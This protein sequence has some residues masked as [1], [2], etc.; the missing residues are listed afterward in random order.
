MIPL[1]RIAM[2]IPQ[3]A[4]VVWGMP[5]YPH[6]N[7]AGGKLG[8]IRVIPIRS[9]KISALIANIVLAA[10]ILSLCFS[11]LFDGVLKG[12]LLLL[13]CQQVIVFPLQFVSVILRLN[14]LYYLSVRICNITLINYVICLFNMNTEST[15][16]QELCS[17][18]AL[19]GCGGADSRPIMHIEKSYMKCQSTYAFRR[20]LHC[21]KE[22]EYQ[23]VCSPRE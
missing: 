6:N 1:I 10:D 22:K 13:G 7:W 23:R 12:G 8:T 9:T 17:T 5:T 11:L 4:N 19:W 21:P 15:V 2:E 20:E 14:K 3:I 16:T 18:Y